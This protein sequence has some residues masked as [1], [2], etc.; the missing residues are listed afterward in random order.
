MPHKS[1]KQVT[2]SSGQNLLAPVFI[3]LVNGFCPVNEVISGRVEVLCLEKLLQFVYYPKSSDGGQDGGVLTDGERVFQAR[4]FGPH[5]RTCL[6]ELQT[7]SVE[8]SRRLNAA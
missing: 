6:Q 5:R 7:V 4:L 8:S 2:A 1:P 3:S